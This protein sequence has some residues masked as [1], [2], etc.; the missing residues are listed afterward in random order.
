M[1]LIL[2]QI[3]QYIWSFNA[4]NPEGQRDPWRH[5]LQIMSVTIREFWDGLITLRA[6]GLV[7]T[8]LL[9]LVP[10]LAVS[11]S[12]LKGFGVHD[13]LEPT[14]VRL[15]EPLGEKNTEVA[16]RIVSFVENLD[17]SV[18]GAIGLILLIYTA[19]SLIQKI[20][21]AFN[22]MWRLTHSRSLIQR[23]T[24][25]L[26]VIMVGPVLVVAA[27]AITA[28]LG[29]YHL[30]SMLNALPFMNDLL[31]FIGK[32]LPYLLVIV[33][34]TFVYLVVP[35]TRVAIRSA[36][37]G[38]VVA[39]VLWQLSG[40][41]FTSF[42]AGST[43]Y[44]V[45][46]SSFAILLVFMIWLYVSWAIL[47]IGACVSFYHQNPE[48]LR[49]GKG[50]FHL[51]SRMRD[52][53]ALQV[54]LNIARSHDGQSELQP[55]L[56]NLAAYQ[57]VPMPMMLRVLE[58]LEADGLVTRSAHTPARYMPARSLSRISIIDILVSARIAEDAGRSE[59]VHCDQEVAELTDRLERGLKSL[60]DEQSLADLIKSEDQE[61][62]ED[63]I[64]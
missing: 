47:L 37:Y 32:I 33:A 6:M 2:E 46:Y 28:S 25:Y 12:V 9:S 7:Y 53:L 52:Q 26:S 13:Q 4:C 51:S 45:I 36:F 50:G 35:N 24:D 20:E 27:V 43:S 49:L 58:A 34:F 23:F 62:D 15:L 18:L 38:G 5:F 41:L 1:K 31:R 29:S 54:M 19:I 30:V 56:E 17:F 40:V 21:S 48:Y 14:L 8:T 3:S 57:Q 42:V 60:L 11:I 55:T 64:V 44:T 59:Q 22:H 39:G 61:S 16:G 63:R 10:L